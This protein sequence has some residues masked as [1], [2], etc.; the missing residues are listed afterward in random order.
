MPNAHDLLELYKAGS[1]VQELAG[2]FGRPYSTVHA[3]LRSV[4][5]KFR[6]DMPPRKRQISVEKIAALY[7]SGKNTVEISKLAAL[8]PAVVN[9]LLRRAG[10]QLRSASEAGLLRYRD[11]SPDERKAITAAAHV[12]ARGRKAG[13]VELC[14]RAQGRQCIEPS[15]Y[16]AEMI[17]TLNSA[18]L[19]IATQTPCGPYNIDITIESAIAVEIFGGEWHASGRHAARFPKRAR[20]ILDANWH[21]LIVWVDARGEWLDGANREIFALLDFARRYPTAIRQY[22]VIDSKGKLRIALDANADDF[23]LKPSFKAR[24]DATGNDLN[25]ITD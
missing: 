4:G 21:L 9:Y 16:E 22:R 24:R 5:C 11:S 8:S 19:R 20:H 3:K 10:V 18:G 25:V 6:C 13:F 12:A 15:G 7:R 14:R 23:P 1:S 2:R 17:S